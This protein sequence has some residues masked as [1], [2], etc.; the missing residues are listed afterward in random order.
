MMPPLLDDTAVDDPLSAAVNAFLEAKRTGLS[1]DRNALRRAHPDLAVDLDR[2][3]AAH[4]AVEKLARPLRE[5]AQAARLVA[6]GDNESPRGHNRLAAPLQFGDYT[7]LEVLGSGGMGIVY[8]A[9]H[10][11]L[12]RDVALK[13][14]IT[15]PLATEADIQRFR[16]EAE[17]A[18]KLEHANIVPVHEVGE[19]DGRHY[20]TMRLMEGGSLASHLKDCQSDPRA[21]ARL[22]V[23]I[24]HAVHHAHQ[25][26]ILH[27]DLKPSNILL[28]KGGT[29]HVTDFGLARRIGDE[30]TLTGSDV[31]L[32]TP[33]Y[34][35]PE[36]AAGRTKEITTATDVYGL[37]AILYALLTGRP[38][39]RG[40]SALETLEK[41]RSTEPEPPRRFNSR[42]DR[43]L[44]TIV[45]KAIAKEPGGRYGTALDM[46]NDLEHWLSGDPIAARPD[47]AVAKAWHWARRNRAVAALLCAV[48][49]LAG[50]G[51]IGLLVN[52]VVLTRKNAEISRQRNRAR[53]AVDKWFTEVA[54]RELFDAPGMVQVRREFLIAARDYYEEEAARGYG[55][56]P[57]SRI[58]RANA[59]FRVG[60]IHYILSEYDAAIRDHTQAVSLLESLVDEHPG[61][62][63]LRSLLAQSLTELGLAYWHTNRRLEAERFIRRGLETARE[64]TSTF[65]DQPE[66]RDTM[67]KSLHDLGILYQENGELP[68]AESA[69]REAIA[70]H[71]TLVASV[72]GSAQCRSALAVDLGAFAG[73]MGDRRWPT[74]RL[75]E[76]EAALRDAV[77]IQEGLAAEFPSTSGHL[78]AEAAL[79]NNLGDLLV[80]RGKLEEAETIQK[81]AVALREQLA[82]RGSR[83]GCSRSSS[84]AGCRGP[85]TGRSIAR[86]GK[87]CRG[88]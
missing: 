40:D 85:H 2:F 42:V 58:E 88:V 16:N 7:L 64:A 54:E 33:S 83:S 84:G 50:A 14:I 82:A 68:R 19:N 21:A 17:S 47:R 23:A 12:K 6:N 71:P 38:P 66:F 80:K 48:G 86:P 39:F 41:V 28:D 32:G 8:R 27:R 18:A 25:R 69:L 59:Y 4:D 37:G 53:Q 61:E 79:E 20:L 10:A 15:G 52:N 77:K 35:A 26:G 13:Q 56:D 9:H 63:N 78:S 43:D 34:M 5:V 51:V 87:I 36:Q 24:A 60:R 31:I 74:A 49:V 76:A 75:D 73:L 62:P 46:A 55:S 30:S 70:V 11:E 1:P 57:S 72:S 44:E 67:A 81:K 29:P 3:F 45:V 65:S 22:V